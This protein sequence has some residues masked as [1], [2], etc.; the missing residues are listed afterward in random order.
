MS[1][2]PPPTDLPHLSVWNLALGAAPSPLLLRRDRPFDIEASS[3]RVP[4]VL[5]PYMGGRE[6]IGRAL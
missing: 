2:A 3:V 1:S 5:V 4:D 6:V